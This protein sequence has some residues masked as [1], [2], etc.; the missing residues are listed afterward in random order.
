MVCGVPS[1]ISLFIGHGALADP[2]WVNWCSWTGQ[3]MIGLKDE[4]LGAH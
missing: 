4:A 3:T 1:G 2:V